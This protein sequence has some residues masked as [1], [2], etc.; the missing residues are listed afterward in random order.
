MPATL[1]YPGVYI[2]EI[3]SGVHTITGVAT[4]IT[5]FIGRTLRG[6]VND[7]ITINSFADFER[8]FGG[9]WQSSPLS[10]AV[11]DFYLNGGSQAVII[12]LYA[13]FFADAAAN[14][15][16]INDATNDAQAAANAVSAATAAVPPAA[17]A[18]T[19]AAAANVELGNIKTASPP[20]AAAVAA[21]ETV[22]AAAQT[23]ASRLPY[24]SKTQRMDL[25][26]TPTVGDITLHFGADDAGPILFTDL[27][28]AIFEGLLNSLT[29]MSTNHVTVTETGTLPNV[30]F[31]FAF[32]NTP[33]DQLTVTTDNGFDAVVSMAPQPPDRASV[34]QAAADAVTL[35]VAKAI[36]SVA[37]LNRARLSLGSTNILDLEAANPGVWG[38]RLRGRIDHDVDPNTT[39][40]FN[41]TVRDGGSG[42]V[43]T[44][45]NISVDPN[46][47]RY[48][49]RVLE[50]ESKL[51]RT[52]GA[53]PGSVPDANNPVAAGG[54]A[55]G[56]VPSGADPFDSLYSTEVVIGGGGEA[57]DGN[58]PAPIDYAGSPVAKTGIYALEKTDLFN[59]LCIPPFSFAKD[60]DAATWAIAASYCVDRRA[61]LIVDAPS[62]WV[63]KDAAK[64]PT[65][66]GA[67]G[68]NSKNAAVFF[69]RLRQ[70]NLLHD[71]Q[72]ETFAPCGAVAGVF[73]R[74][75]TQRGVWKAPAGLEATLVGVPQ[76]S[77][78]LTDG[79]N[80]ELNPLGINCLRAVPAAGR[81]IW[82]SRTLQGAD[83]LASEWKYIP[84]RRMA[85]FLEESL[86]RGTQWVVFEPNDEPLWAQI[87]LNLGAFMHN[88]FRQGAFQGMT[89]KDAYFVK[90]DKETT[91][92]TD[93]NLG[94]VNILV[95]FAPLKPA[96]FV[97][98]KIQQMAG[99]I[100]T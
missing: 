37:P 16:A 43:E 31:E 26:G 67:L 53:M 23:E 80:G 100:E 4:S 85:L 24:I 46:H 82:G 71:N 70:P 5:A 7:P 32:T 44:F 27:T 28:A 94:I 81:V 56:V 86:Y 91:T 8:V 60:V 59:L 72:L 66:I 20:S 68:T 87:R 3:S 89:P 22:A 74:T 10:F 47:T 98:I 76:L 33:S 95:G 14:S 48:V 12:R 30:S 77:V 61:M 9:L 45:R 96:E 63:D 15:Q 50:Q 52:V 19:A 79:E 75:D 73:A 11:R 2:E 29:S 88:L 34:V 62:T 99:Q 93:I 64:A 55:A 6:P 41:L 21:A 57:S 92:Q 54:V 38:N 49:T 78:P 83:R 17:S 42:A 35:A 36:A 25:S 58:D 1:S 13:P 51:V 40:L 65:G 69:P 90:C 39:G 18:T 84:V 97:V